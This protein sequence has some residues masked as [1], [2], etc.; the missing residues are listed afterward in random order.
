L[1]NNIAL[2]FFFLKNHPFNKPEMIKPS[3]KGIANLQKFKP[4]QNIFAKKIGR[5]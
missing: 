1:Q 2:F 4:V 3:L 5:L